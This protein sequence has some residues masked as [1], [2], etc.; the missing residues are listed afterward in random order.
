M[1]G[2]NMNKQE[3][4]EYLNNFKDFYNV[5]IALMRNNWKQEKEEEIDERFEGMKDFKILENEE[6]NVIEILQPHY[7]LINKS[8]KTYFRKE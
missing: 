3:T 8:L 7:F 6:E 1:Q 5:L 4:I 2:V